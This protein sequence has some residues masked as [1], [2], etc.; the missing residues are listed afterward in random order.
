MAKAP[1]GP[2]VV[3]PITAAPFNSSTLAFG[4]AF[5][6]TTSE[7][8]PSTRTT[9][10]VGRTGPAA[11][12]GAAPCSG[13]LAGVAPAAG[14]AGFMASVPDGTD[15][16]VVGLTVS[17]AGGVTSCTPVPGDTSAGFSGLPGGGLS[18]ATSAGGCGLKY[19]SSAP[20]T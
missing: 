9:S 14:A 6:A 8:S 1:S 16:S 10:N 2:A 17:P 11:T 20:D 13:F 5:P 4:A 3:E 18:A 19:G 15:A 7:P 12:A